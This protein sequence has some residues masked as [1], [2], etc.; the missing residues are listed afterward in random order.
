MRCADVEKQISRLVDGELPESLAAQVAAHLDLCEAC[1]A[2]QE[3]VVSLNA[4]LM[5]FPVSPVSADLAARVRESITHQRGYE[6]RPFLIPAWCR[7]PLMAALVLVALGIGG[8]SG[9]SIGELVMQPRSEISMEDVIPGQTGSFAQVAF[10]LFGQDS[11][12]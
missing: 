9:R 11:D 1:L 3:Q 7:V 8:I 10:D 4:R 2:F 5:A 6:L 12:K